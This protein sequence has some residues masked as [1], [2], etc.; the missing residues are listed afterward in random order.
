MGLDPLADAGVGHATLGG[1]VSDLDVV[2][3]V[4]GV[5]PV[6]VMVEGGD[7]GGCPVDVQVVIPLCVH[8]PPIVLYDPCGLL[9]GGPA[10]SEDELVVGGGLDGLAV[11]QRDAEDRL[12]PVLE[13]IHH[14]GPLNRKRLLVDLPHLHL[15]NPVPFEVG[16]LLIAGVARVLG[17]LEPLPDVLDLDLVELVPTPLDAAGEVEVDLGALGQTRRAV[18]DLLP[19]GVHRHPDAEHD[20]AHLERRAMTPPEQIAEQMSVG[21]VRE[22]LRLASEADA[23][24]VGDG[25][26]VPEDADQLDEAP[27][28]NLL[29]FRER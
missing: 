12:D 11:S 20:L 15:T 18:P 1:D 6:A 23:G 9:E 13:H 3:V 22:F 21:H 17:R 5:E 26:V 7:F 14:A 4:A 24:G 2:H 27:G 19:V 25:V 16:V 8:G 29:R 28:K 10:V